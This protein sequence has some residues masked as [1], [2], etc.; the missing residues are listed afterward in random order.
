MSLARS[1]AEVL[2]EHVTLEIDGIDRL[3]LNLYVPQLMHALGVVSFFRFHQ[4]YAFASSALMEPITNAFIAGIE[5]CAREH[6]VP[7]I[8]F[9]KGQRKDDVAARY[10]AAFTVDEGILF[11]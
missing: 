4:G 8:P 11:I 2:K 5:R 6:A 1:V 10:R 9:A 7:L 3:Y